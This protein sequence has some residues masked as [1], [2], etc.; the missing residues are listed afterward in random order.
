M[1]NK[2][3][4]FRFARLSDEHKIQTIQEALK[5]HSD[6]ARNIFEAINKHLQKQE[7]L[8][9]AIHRKKAITS[10]DQE[11]INKI[12][13][14]EVKKRK[15]KPSIAE[16]KL[17]FYFFEIKKLREQEKLSWQ[18]IQQY[19]RKTHHLK[20]SYVTIKNFYLKYKSII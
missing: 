10:A 15:K 3:L 8:L 6:Q 14:D 12:K 13:L 2:N 11:L 18:K 4:W 20:F 17:K 19:L 9:S 16:K 1:D 7:L 5:T